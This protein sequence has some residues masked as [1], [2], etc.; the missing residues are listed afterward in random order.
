MATQIGTFPTAHASRYLQQ[1]CKHFGHKVEVSYDERTGRAAL[2]P[3]P[4]R[5]W[6]DDDMLQLEVTAGT[7]E[8]LG[9]ARYVIDSH[10]E[11]FAYRE[12]FKAM[13]WAV[14]EGL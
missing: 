13:D 10:L 7:E 11:T 2:P 14:A 5:M 6:A 12:K 9:T 1:L 3:G 4:A 8:G